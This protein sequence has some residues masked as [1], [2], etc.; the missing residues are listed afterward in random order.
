MHRMIMIYAGHIGHKVI[1]YMVDV[2]G[3]IRSSPQTE[4]N[5]SAKMLL[6]YERHKSI[7]RI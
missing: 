1:F 7:Y 6:T 2:N 4:E 3:Y 5:D